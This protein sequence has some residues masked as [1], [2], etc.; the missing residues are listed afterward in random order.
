[1]EENNNGI[2]YK[3]YYYCKYKRNLPLR[4]EVQEEKN[5]Y[6][7]NPN[8]I[9]QYDK[10]ER[11]NTQKNIS[12]R[13]NEKKSNKKPY[14]KA[15]WSYI[16]VII[17]LFITI[18]AMVVVDYLGYEKLKSRPTWISGS[19]KVYYAIEMNSFSD[20]DSAYVFADALRKQGGGGFIL[21]EDSYYKVLAAMYKTE[22]D[23][24]TIC[25]RL[26]LNENMA[27]VYY[28]TIPK[29]EFNNY[30]IRDRE[31][32]LNVMEY[33]NVIYECLY[34]VS[35]DLDKEMI[36]NESAINKIKL[37]KEK[38]VSTKQQLDNNLASTEIN[39]QIIKIKA[40]LVSAIAILDNLTNNR[41]ARPNLL[42]DIRYSYIL[43]VHNYI[44]LVNSL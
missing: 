1:M 3:N 12:K 37:L 9:I 2:D 24:K 13:Y 38:I 5:S 16:F 20:Y 21:K 34:S 4:Q 6:V 8:H 7:Q 41:L 10:Y 17:V 33:Y 18:C 39:T 30:E 40:E 31:I 14:N 22:T 26:I 32:I 42:C 23:A 35:N 29:V 25:E 36:N 11:R 28:F 43:V 19:N 15:K 27:R 44:N